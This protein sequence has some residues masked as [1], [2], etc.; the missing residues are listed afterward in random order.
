MSSALTG[1]RVEASPDLERLW[2]S[3]HHPV[4]VILAIKLWTLMLCFVYLIDICGRIALHQFIVKVLAQLIL[5]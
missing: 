2:K 5:G 4:E 1:L 3:S